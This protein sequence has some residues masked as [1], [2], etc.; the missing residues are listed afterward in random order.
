[1]PELERTGLAGLR[2]TLLQLSAL[3]SE[4]RL[5]HPA[6]AKRGRAEQRIEIEGSGRGYR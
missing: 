2:G 3:M 1:M 5:K 4:A 6:S